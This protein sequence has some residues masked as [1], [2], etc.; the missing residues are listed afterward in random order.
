M[1]RHIVMVKIKSSLDIALTCKMFKDKLLTLTEKIPD[2]IHMEV[3]ININLKPSA[4]DLVL[5]ADFDN[6]E[7]L[8]RYRIHV[9]HLSVLEYMNEI[10]E[11][12]V[13]VDYYLL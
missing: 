1:F 6:E 9:E 10:V 3:G 11:K 13:V 12:V 7:G 8:N 4:Y 5:T 2:L